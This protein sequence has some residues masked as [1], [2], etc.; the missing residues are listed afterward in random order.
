MKGTKIKLLMAFM[1]IAGFAY[2][3]QNQGSMTNQEVVEKFLSGFNDPT[4]FPESLML[5]ADDY[6]FKNPMVELHSKA[7]FLALAQ[8]IAKVVNGIE[9]ISYA[10]DGEW[11]GTFYKFN[12]S[13]PGL[14]SNIA[15]EW[16]RVENG[17]IQES[18]MIYDASEWRKVYEQ[19]GN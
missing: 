19:M 7:E 3:Q 18:E 1:L 10:Q 15:S 17:M 13:I 2:S 6:R 4:K 9:V 14:E 11:V 16:F 8:E 12:S 5:L